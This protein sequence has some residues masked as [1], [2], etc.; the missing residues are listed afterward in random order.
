MT[1]AKQ[2]VSVCMESDASASKSHVPAS[3]FV[4]KQRQAQIACDLI[5]QLFKGL[6]TE[7]LQE[8][9]QWSLNQ[10]QLEFFSEPDGP[11]SK[12]GEPNVRKDYVDIAELRTLMQ[13]P[14]ATRLTIFFFLF[15]VHAELKERVLDMDHSNRAKIVRFMSDMRKRVVLDFCVDERQSPCEFVQTA[16]DCYMLA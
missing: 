10:L 6:Q 9:V 5:E 11:A 4:P 1:C 16:H 2:R 13:G 14:L 3:Q 12:P 7:L 15:N 8:L